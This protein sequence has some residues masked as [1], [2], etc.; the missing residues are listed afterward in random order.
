[1]TALCRVHGGMA[2]A[3]LGNTTALSELVI[4]LAG[5]LFEDPEFVALHRRVAD[6]I[7]PLAQRTDRDRRRMK[8]LMDVE[9]EKLGPLCCHVGEAAWVQAIDAIE[10]RA[11]R[12]AIEQADQER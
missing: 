7:V 1:M 11:I 6:E 8:A 5:L 10:Q 12:K 4:E 3:R 2:L 9:L